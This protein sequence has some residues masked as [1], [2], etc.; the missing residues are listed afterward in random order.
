[1]TS[2]L[3][4]RAS[5]EMLGAEHV[6][7]ELARSLP[8]FGYRPIIAV[9]VERNHPAPDLLARANVS[10]IETLALPIISAFDPRAVKW[11]RRYLV[12]NDV[13]ILHSHGYRED[14]YA[15]FARIN[16]P[17]V[18]TNHLW[19][20]TNWR[21][22]A[23]AGFDARVLRRFDRIVAVSESVRRDMLQAKIS[24]DNISVIHNGIDP[25]DIKPSQN[26]TAI[27]SGLSIPEERFLF[28]T[29]SSLTPEK[30]HETLLRAFANIAKQHDDAHLAIIGDGPESEK[31]LSM[32]ATTG[33]AAKVTLAGRRDDVANILFAT[34]VFVLPSLSEGLP[35]SLLEAMSAGTPVL[36][37][38]V[39]EVPYVLG[40]GAGQLVEPGNSLA[41]EEALRACINGDL[42]LAEMS[43]VALERV[44]QVFS[45]KE[46]ARKYAEVYRDALSARSICG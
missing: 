29:I 44:V 9:P 23:Y 15:L 4:I 14:L 43:R 36:A 3:H 8:A 22:K 11:L 42:D 30:G 28:S 27:R 35:I 1:M 5:G 40:E 39:G 6:V 38:A 34:D 17:L 10:G 41:L 32:V 46:M 7:L 13:S 21:L 2:V 37:S 20:R 45:A 12:E 31:I 16:Q 25:S 18:A 19:K 33:L 26:R 24:A